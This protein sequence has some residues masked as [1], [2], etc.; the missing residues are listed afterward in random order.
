MLQLSPFLTLP[1]ALLLSAGLAHYAWRLGREGVPPSRRIIRR[2]SVSMMILALVSAAYASSFLE[3]EFVP[4]QRTY[5][6]T[7]GA[8]MALVAGV[9][10]TAVLDS[11]KTF[12]LARRAARDGE[13]DFDL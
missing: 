5:V 12:R 8:V 4:D 1:V 3:P 2:L 7:W 6:T 9:I 11:L 10:L 13:L